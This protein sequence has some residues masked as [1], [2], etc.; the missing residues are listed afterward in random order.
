M[1]VHAALLVFG[2]ASLCS[3]CGL[4]TAGGSSD[5]DA[6]SE[7]YEYSQSSEAEQMYVCP[8]CEGNKQ[9][10]HYYTGEIIDCP[11]CEGS[12]EVS[13]ETVDQLQEADRIGREW[14]EGIVNGNDGNYGSGYSQS[15]S[16]Q[17]IQAEIEQC[18]NEIN[19]LQS[20]L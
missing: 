9:I 16:V 2:V 7:D 5:R 1:K 11:A 6:S 12:G 14:A 20:A 10:A 4:I 17:Q 19:N 3:A 15:R 13:Q 8:M 18:E